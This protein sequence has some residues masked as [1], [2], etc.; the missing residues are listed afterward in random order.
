MQR[1]LNLL[2]RL[3]GTALVS[4]SLVTSAAGSELSNLGDS[5]IRLVVNAKS[6]LSDWKE[7]NL[8]CG[9]FYEQ[10]N[11]STDRG[12]SFGAG[13]AL[14][15]AYMHQGRTDEAMELIRKSFTPL[16][17]A[18]GR[19]LDELLAKEL[20]KT[21]VNPVWEFLAEALRMDDRLEESERLTKHALRLEVEGLGGT[22]KS[23]GMRM[24]QL[25]GVLS[26]QSRHA[27]AAEQLERSVAILDKATGPESFE[28]T[29]AN[30]FLALEY[31]SLGNYEQSERLYRSVLA[32]RVN[33]LGENHPL[34]AQSLSSL[35]SLLDTMGRVT[36]AEPLYQRILRIQES[37][38]GFG[39]PEVAT[40]LSDIADRFA[41]R[42]N[43]TQAEN[44]LQRALAIRIAAFGNDS[45][46]TLSTWTDIADLY[47][48]QSRYKDAEKI[49]RDVL[50]TQEAKFGSKHSQVANTLDSIGSN[51]MSQGSLSEADLAFKR[52]LM[53]REAVFGRNGEAVV[54]SLAWIG[55]LAEE[56]GNIK[57]A[58]ASYRRALVIR[59]RQYGESHPQIADALLNLARHL[60]HYGSPK[61]AEPLISRAIEINRKYFGDMHPSVARAFSDLDDCLRKQKKDK[62]ALEAA[63]KSTWVRAKRI[64]DGLD[65]PPDENL[66]QTFGMH[67]QRLFSS[68]SN[69]EDEG[70]QVA[71]MI[72][73]SATAKAIANMAIRSGNA[74]VAGLLKVIQE[75]I[76]RRDVLEQQLLSNAGL[77][78]EKRNPADELRKR[79]ELDLLDGKIAALNADLAKDFPEFADLAKPIPITSH[80]TQK[81]LADHEALLAWYVLED[82]T[83]LFWLSKS[84][85]GFDVIPTGR[86]ALSSLVQKLRASTEIPVAGDLLPYPRDT[87]KELYRILFGKLPAHLQRYKH[88]I[89]VPDGPLQSLSFG[90]L[91]VGGSS[92][93][94]DDPEVPQWLVRQYAIT[95]LPTITSLRALRKFA[96]EPGQREP[97][98]GFG[99]PD[100]KGDGGDTRGVKLSRLFSRGL[101][102]DT[103]AVSEMQPLPATADE[104]QS[105]AK[106]LKADANSI[107]LKQ[108]ATETTVKKLPLNKYRT[109]AF[110]THGIIAGEFKGVQEP[111]LVLTPPSEGTD[112]DDGLLTASE[113]AGLKL[114]ADWVILSACNTAA[115]DGTPGAQG[116][117]GLTKA[118]FYAG[119]RALLVSHWAV[120]SNSAMKLTTRMFEEIEKGATKAEALR[121]SMMALADDP[122]TSHPAFWA[123][124]V[125]VGEGAR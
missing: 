112:T 72:N 75:S 87:A 83:L 4:F 7:A 3:L 73:M 34:V 110:A 111:A 49:Y 62:E 26:A 114:D 25:A 55:M 80:E 64:I 38:L 124:F 21:E 116:F 16:S 2:V 44:F 42:G 36:E 101:V 43:F 67:T 53:I 115:P 74:E 118:F 51:L 32:T 22:H 37:A 39:N 77:P 59:E 125:V 11:N 78:P 100:L 120:E 46:A 9:R 82:R 10:S 89:L 35:A 117:T 90:M 96:K 18:D 24:T 84:E 71:Q 69:L 50:S 48:Q 68:S 76:A 30:N 31:E 1:L 98:V 57:E 19:S 41:D 79:Q 17:K 28:A 91:E 92:A 95:T 27:E 65:G 121:L 93:P 94:S 123:P 15:I 103:R 52:S 14:G 105:I 106:S 108:A 33:T 97:F 45:S 60:V 119:A 29:L 88:L 47:V 8:I 20:N 113:V 102:A 12:A 6:G 122:E 85:V 40:A 99:D 54:T 5:C 81:L 109:V 107:Y 13:V 23:V 58:E 70:F 63:R 56:R 104:L 86:L 61:K 66:R